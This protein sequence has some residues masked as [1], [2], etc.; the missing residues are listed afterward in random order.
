MTKAEN[1]KQRRPDGLAGRA[2]Y[3]LKRVL[4]P[5]CLESDGIRVSGAHTRAG[6]INWLSRRA[7]VLTLVL[8]VVLQY[9][10]SNT[11]QKSAADGAENRE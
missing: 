2:Q 4:A 1:E 3:A 8:K 9:R 5:E 6:M 7:S 11:G 10:R